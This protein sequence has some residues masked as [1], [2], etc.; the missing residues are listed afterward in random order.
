MDQTLNDE[1]A[2]SALPA[3]SDPAAPD[4]AEVAALRAAILDKLTYA[5]GKDPGHAQPHDWF[6]A[7]ALAVRD[8][9]VDRW[10]RCHAQDLPRRPQARLLPVARVPDRPAAVRRAEQPRPHATGARGARRARRRSRPAAQSSS[11]TRRS[12][13][14]ASAASPPASWRAW[15]RSASPAYGYGIRYDH[16]IFRQVIQDGW[17]HELPEDWLVVRQSVGIRAAGGRLHDRLRR[18][19][20]SDDRRRRRRSPRMSWH[21]GGDR[22]PRSPS[23]R[24]S[25]AG[26]G[27]HVNTLRLWSAR[28]ADPLARRLQPRR[29]RRRAGRPRARRGDLARALSERRHAGRP[30]AAAAAGIFLRVRVAAGPGA[31][32]QAAARRAVVARRPR[33]DPAERHAPGDRHRR[34]D[35]PPGRRARHAVGRRLADHDRRRSTTPT[36]RCCPRRSRPGPCRCSSGCCRGTCRSSTCINALHL[37]ALRAKAGTSDGASLSSVSLIE[38]HH[39]AARAHGPSRLPRIAH[40]STACRRCTPS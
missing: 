33:R 37:D 8:R 29:P 1:T 20:A 38:E 35:A 10:M 15:R 39:G 17:Q 19:G 9:I 27:A 26:A 3:E 25:S 7:T 5:V 24:R 12:A 23:T 32:A 21:P 2:S 16:G 13:T 6:M 30:G 28:A 4:S 22:R 36:T 40:A 11:P 18:H 14:A 31:P 34:A